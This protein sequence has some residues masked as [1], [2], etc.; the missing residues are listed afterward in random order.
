MTAFVLI[1]LLISEGIFIFGFAIF[2]FWVSRLRFPLIILAALLTIFSA[3]MSTVVFWWLFGVWYQFFMLGVLAITAGFLVIGLFLQIVGNA[4][5]PDKNERANVLSALE[6]HIRQRGLTQYL[7]L[8]AFFA[9]IAVIYITY[10]MSRGGIN[11]ETIKSATFFFFTVGSVPGLILSSLQTTRAALDRTVDSVVRNIL[12]INTLGGYAAVAWRASF[13][14]IY[15]GGTY[16]TLGYELDLY[17]VLAM[18]GT[19][20]LLFVIIPLLTGARL[21]AEERRRVVDETDRLLGRVVALG[22][23]GVSERILKEQGRKVASAINQMLIGL[24]KNDGLM[25]FL[26]FWRWGPDCLFKGDGKYWVLIENPKAES[27]AQPSATANEPYRQPLGVVARPWFRELIGEDRRFRQN[28]LIEAQASA[29]L[30]QIPTW[31]YRAA[32]FDA[33]VPVLEELEGSEPQDAPGLAKLA[34][35]QL[36]GDVLEPGGRSVVTAFFM[37]IFTIIGPMGL[38]MFDSQIKELLLT[39]IKT[40]KGG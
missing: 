4:F 39:T 7:S 23:P 36:K 22:E 9:M 27:G 8:I 32:T 34:Q 17:M 40:I 29:F 25:R 1:L 14:F 11:P 12:A 2:V 33:L 38:S 15:F 31:N 20:Y 24:F 18:V 3:F 13:P 16:S 21:Y 5:S 6:G 26:A 19:I 10:S 28:K 30:E 35:V 37:T